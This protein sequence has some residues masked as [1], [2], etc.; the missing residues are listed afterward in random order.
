[1]NS[2]TGKYNKKNTVLGEPRENDRNKKRGTEMYIDRHTEVFRR[3]QDVLEGNCMTHALRRT[4][5][6]IGLKTDNSLLV[7]TAYHALQL[8]GA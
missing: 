7:F 3:E 5:I 4:I 6:I 1:M 2:K 8:R